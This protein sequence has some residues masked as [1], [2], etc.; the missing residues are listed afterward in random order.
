MKN[1]SILFLV[2][3]LSCKAQIID[4]YNPDNL[5]SFITGAYYKDVTNF[6]D[7]FVG[8]WLYT[9]GSNSLTV[10]LRKRDSLYDIGNNSYQDIMIGAYKYIENGVE[11]VNTLYQIDQSFGND[12]LTNIKN[13]YLVSHTY[14][15]YPEN[16]P[17]CTECNVNEK[18]LVF[19][20]SEP[21]YNADYLASNHFV[22]RSFIEN[23]IH[24][25]K[26]WFYERNQIATLN[27]DNT[28]NE[29][30]SYKLPQGVYILTKQ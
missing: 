9:N 15:P 16:Y 5:G 2:C 25:I 17:Y 26:V 13:Y 6:R 1:Y 28:I 22:I 19:T 8:T 4:K 7:Q 30:E 20:L 24:K 18:R 11:K 29:P 10:M 23:G 14:K 12:L 21:G 27:S 3:F